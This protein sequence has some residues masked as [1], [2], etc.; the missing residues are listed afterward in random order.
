MA[1]EKSELAR[2][3]RAHTQTHTHLSHD[4]TVS[5]LDAHRT[6]RDACEV[7]RRDL[8]LTTRAESARATSD[9]TLLVPTRLQ[10]ARA[11]SRHNGAADGDGAR[12]RAR[13]PRARAPVSRSERS[14]S[15]TACTVPRAPVRRGPAPGR[16]RGHLR[17]RT[18]PPPL[19]L[20]CSRG[21]WYV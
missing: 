15:A 13:A 12:P 1:D 14:A 17:T 4:G 9:L 6:G 3:P 2:A 11:K 18:S 21:K 8:K 19:F 10:N 20:R 7:S 16:A 5:R